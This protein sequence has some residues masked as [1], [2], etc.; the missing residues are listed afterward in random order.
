[1]PPSVRPLN[2]ESQTP[3]A[4]SASW[5]VGRRASALQKS[6]AGSPPVCQQS[7]LA[8]FKFSLSE[9]SGA[10][11]N[12]GSQAI[13]AMFLACARLRRR[14]PSVKA[15]LGPAAPPQVTM[16]S[17]FNTM[18]L[19]QLVKCCQAENWQCTERLAAFAKEREQ[20]IRGSQVVEDGFQRERRQEAEGRTIRSASR[21]HGRC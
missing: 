12:R 2:L 11:P 10:V 5:A 7:S 14:P 21:R 18:P 16:R 15:D 9:C 20:V 13:V 19:M 1:M 3:I 8:K 6:W 17:P 4:L